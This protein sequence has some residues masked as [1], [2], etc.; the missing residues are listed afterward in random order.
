MFEEGFFKRLWGSIDRVLFGFDLIVAFLLSLS[1][2]V[3][4]PEFL[5][6]DTAPSFIESTVPL[7]TTLIIVTVTSV[8]I[9]VSL[10]N[11]SVITQLKKEQLYEKFLFTF[12]F[13]A[14]LALLS[15]TLSIFAQLFTVGRTGV[16]IFLFFILYTVLAAAT[17]IS[18]LI[19]YGDKIALMSL[20][21]E[22]PDDLDERTKKIKEGDEGD[23]AS[24]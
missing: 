2:Y 23:E 10:S 20:A 19:T 14:M 24:G 12:E 3:F 4:F 6:E 9:L 7:L 11:S 17:V 1:L 18:R 21:E 22:L 15:S 16:H 5:T 8:S 13:T